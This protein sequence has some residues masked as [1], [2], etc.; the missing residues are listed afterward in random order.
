MLVTSDM[1]LEKYITNYGE[2]TKSY[3]KT[4]SNQTQTIIC[5]Y[6][7]CVGLPCQGSLALSALY[8]TTHLL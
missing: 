2:N 3:Q 7:L 4:S 1:C 6:Y 8:L 5:Y